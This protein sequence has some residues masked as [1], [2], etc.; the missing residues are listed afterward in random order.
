MI[1]IT[2]IITYKIMAAVEVYIE[3][4]IKYVTNC[5]PMGPTV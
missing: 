4:F 2:L 3:C 1:S 5:K